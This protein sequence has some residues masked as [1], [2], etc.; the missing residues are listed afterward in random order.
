[1]SIWLQEDERGG[2]GGGRE[3]REMRKGRGGVPDMV[4]R[5]GGLCVKKRWRGGGAKKVLKIKVKRS[6]KHG[7]VLSLLS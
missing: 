6:G 2:A 7:V 3:G 4:M 1:M 5:Q